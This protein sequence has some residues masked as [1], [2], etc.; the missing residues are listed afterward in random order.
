MGEIKGILVVKVNL[1]EKKIIGMVCIIT[2]ERLE[3]RVSRFK[4]KV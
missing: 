1:E 2:F 3:T 4:R